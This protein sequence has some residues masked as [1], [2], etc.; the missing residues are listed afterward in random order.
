[1][2]TD[3]KTKNNKLRFIIIVCV[4]LIAAIAAVGIYFVHR[5]AQDEKIPAFKVETPFAEIEYPSARK[6]N[7]N[8]EWD[9][10]NN[11]GKLIF[12]AKIQDKEEIEIFSIHFNEDA[13]IP[14]GILSEEKGGK[15]RIG[16]SLANPQFDESWSDYEKDIFYAMQDDINFLIRQLS[17]NKAFKAE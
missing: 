5:N 7:L 2:E 13:Q 15:I 16:Y 9:G 17:K 1:M 3:V 12:F 6:E 8:I 14:I 10:T 4:V 11:E